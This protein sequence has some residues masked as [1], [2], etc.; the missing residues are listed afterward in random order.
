M[1]LGMLC[2]AM[3]EYMKWDMLLEDWPLFRNKLN[4][5]DM[6]Q[7]CETCFSFGVVQITQ[8]YNDFLDILYIRRVAKECFITEEWNK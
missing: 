1:E 6:N 7:C 3:S 8:G 5:W 4:D 2:S